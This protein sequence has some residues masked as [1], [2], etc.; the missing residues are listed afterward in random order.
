MN[1]VEFT[2]RK[3]KVYVN[4]HF[5]T[6]LMACD[7]G[8]PLSGSIDGGTDICMFGEAHISVDQDI[9]DVKNKITNVAYYNITS[10]VDA[11][12]TAI[13]QSR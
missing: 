7:D 1:F 3:L 8:H 12:K 6:G 13:I 10:I 4:P 9:E 5:V 2:H 11:I